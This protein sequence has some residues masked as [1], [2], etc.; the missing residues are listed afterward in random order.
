[1][2]S[3]KCANLLSSK[4]EAWMRRYENARRTGEQMGLT[5]STVPADRRAVFLDVVLKL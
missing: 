1:M 3:D 4:R 5:L 2:T